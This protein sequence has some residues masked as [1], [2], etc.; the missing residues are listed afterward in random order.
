MKTDKTDKKDFDRYIYEVVSKN[1]KY[2]RIHNNSKYADNYGRITQEKLAFELNTVQ[3]VIANYENGKHLIA[4]P[5][6]YDICKLYE[7][8]ADY[9]LGR[10]DKKITFKKEDKID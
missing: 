10:I 2:Y 9:L 5:F 6:L 4:L 8:S 1:I 7:I 3:A